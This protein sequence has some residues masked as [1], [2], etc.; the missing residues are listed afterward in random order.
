MTKKQ[1]EILKNKAK[2]A[3]RNYAHDTNKMME[4]IKRI[5]SF[6]QESYEM[7]LIN[8]YS[9]VIK[10]QKEIGLAAMEELDKLQKEIA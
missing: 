1:I 2:L 8:E 4:E 6:I 5:N 9:E 3:V 7:Y 10:L